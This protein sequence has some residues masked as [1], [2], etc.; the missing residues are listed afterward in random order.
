[1]K[2]FKVEADKEQIEKEL[3]VKIK[4]FVKGQINTGETEEM[5]LPDGTT[6][7]VPVTRV[8]IEIDFEKEPSVDA[9][10]RLDGLLIDMRRSDKPKRN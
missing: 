4:R 7:T 10:D 1:M 8:G 3:G 2:W 5:I 9:L 6:Q